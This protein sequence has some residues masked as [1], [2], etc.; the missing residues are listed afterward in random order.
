[1]RSRA[2]FEAIEVIVASILWHSSR[3]NEARASANSPEGLPATRRWCGSAVELLNLLLAAHRPW[4]TSSV[5]DIV[6]G[7]S[8]PSTLL[9][10]PGEQV[11]STLRAC[12]VRA[13]CCRCH[14][15]TSH[16]ARDADASATRA[17]SW[18]LNSRGR[19]RLRS[20][21][22]PS[23]AADSSR[24]SD[25]SCLLSKVASGNTVIGNMCCHFSDIRNRFLN[26]F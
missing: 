23:R 13:G 14:L 24:F 25:S 1:M 19:C 21:V 2:L 17:I 8:S 10:G 6:H 22:M 7:G 5:R 16:W 15:R 9:A 3:A 26:I 12:R 4:E 18:S 11:D 20:C